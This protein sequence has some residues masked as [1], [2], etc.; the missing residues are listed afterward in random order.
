VQNSWSRRLLARK[1]ILYNLSETPEERWERGG[2]KANSEREGKEL[3]GEFP[4]LKRTDFLGAEREP[5]KGWGK[6]CK[7]AFRGTRAGR[8]RNFLVAPENQSREGERRRKK[9]AI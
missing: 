3:P 7:G 2:K 9:G 8:S 1:G 6:V 5:G 4:F